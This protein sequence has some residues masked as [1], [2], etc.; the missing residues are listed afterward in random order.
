[1]TEEQKYPKWF[2][3]ASLGKSSR[4]ATAPS[5]CPELLAEGPRILSTPRLN[6]A[7]S[8]P[9][10]CLWE[11]SPATR[12]PFLGALCPPWEHAPPSGAPQFRQRMPTLA[13]QIASNSF[14]S[15]AHAS[16]LRIVAEF[17]DAVVV[18]AMVLRLG[19]HRHHPGS[20]LGPKRRSPSLGAP[21]LQSREVWMD[22][23]GLSPS[24]LFP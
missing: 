5:T 23:G 12:P 4:M 10:F 13:E 6:L 14:K 21:V 1:M 16:Y 18:M 15:E 7:I 17:W 9:W 24:L 11:V 19:N 20:Y 2:C 3:L 22:S 8:I